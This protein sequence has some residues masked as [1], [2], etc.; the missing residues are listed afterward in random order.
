MAFKIGSTT[1]VNNSIQIPWSQ[2]DLSSYG[3]YINSVYFT[4]SDKI[5][6][7]YNSGSVLYIIR[8]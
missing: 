8:T 7:V 6:N 1:I 2:I 3:N 5:I 4:G